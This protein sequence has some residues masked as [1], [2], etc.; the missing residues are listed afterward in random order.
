MRD[1]I[2]A[3]KEVDHEDEETMDRKRRRTEKI[4]GCVFILTGLAWLLTG[5]L[6]L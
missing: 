5:I 3:I 6:C 4:S 1:L 2:G